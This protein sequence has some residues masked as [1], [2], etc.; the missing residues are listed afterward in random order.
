MGPPSPFPEAPMSRSTSILPLL[1]VVSQL[2]TGCLQWR[3]DPTPL[4]ARLRA[5]HPSDFRIWL[6]DGERIDLI[7]PTI[8]RDTLHGFLKGGS[9]FAV[10]MREVDHYDTQKA[11]VNKWIVYPVLIVGVPLLILMSLPPINPD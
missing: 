9:L 2:L 8:I 5:S 11:A 7:G 1:L 4:P 6:R 10:S 3:A